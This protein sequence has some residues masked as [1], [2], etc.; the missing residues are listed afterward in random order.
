M[1]KERT[2][3]VIDTLISQSPILPDDLLK[4][5]NLLTLARVRSM[6]LTEKSGDIAAHSFNDRLSVLEAANALTSKDDATYPTTVH[7]LI[8]HQSH[9]L[10]RESGVSTSVK[11]LDVLNSLS[12]KA[13]M[14][15]DTCCL[16]GHQNDN[17]LFNLST[18]R[19]MNEFVDFIKTDEIPNKLSLMDYGLASIQK[20]EANL[21]QSDADSI[22]ISFVNLASDKS[23][24]SLINRSQVE[25]DVAAVL[26]SAIGKPFAE[27]LYDLTKETGNDRHAISLLTNKRHGW[28]VGGGDPNSSSYIKSLISIVSKSSESETYL[29]K[30]IS[31]SDNTESTTSMVETLIDAHNNTYHPTNIATLI[32]KVGG[33]LSNEQIN[34]LSNLLLKNS[35]SQPVLN[36]LQAIGDLS[37]A[38][39]YDTEHID[40]AMS[41]IKSR[42]AD[43]FNAL[44]KPISQYSTTTIDFSGINKSVYLSDVRST[45]HLQ[46]MI[47]DMVGDYDGD[48]RFSISA[49]ESELDQSVKRS[50][51]KYL[52]KDDAYD[53]NKLIT[54]PIMDTEREGNA[55]WNQLLF[56]ASK[57]SKV[58]PSSNVPAELKT[59]SNFVE[60]DRL[61]TLSLGS[62]NQLEK[63]LEKLP[64]SELKTSNDILDVIGEYTAS[65][66]KLDSTGLGKSFDKSLTAAI[67]DV[68]KDPSNKS[69][70][71]Q[72][73]DLLG[74]PIDKLSTN[75]EIN[76]N[77]DDKQVKITNTVSTFTKN[78]LIDNKVT[79]TPD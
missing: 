50:L 18:T 3:S 22:A 53:L 58:I 13:S 73:D 68:I 75:I 65:G 71:S 28:L 55:Q 34:R 79:R 41:A 19:R 21:S 17:S 32:N 52:F 40:S 56:E 8:A 57:Q 76:N 61:L 35:E 46:Q 20:Q 47:D 15:V 59:L 36:S 74:L 38:K 77:Y 66:F 27:N 1:L 26:F 29:D 72:L 69:N 7:D 16:I 37:K 9:E 5:S 70:L 4:Q 54:T 30:I 24:S 6:T 31:L 64:L 33:K 23:Y 48:V 12:A 60:K 39:G 62:D 14:V 2:D 42:M 45:P 11:E 10:I 51:E 25:P 78:T 49:S 43:D 63:Q 44:D 67:T